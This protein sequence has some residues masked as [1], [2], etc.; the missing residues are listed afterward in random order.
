VYRKLG[1]LE[2]AR[3]HLR[4]GLEAARVLQ[5]SAEPPDGY[6]AMIIDALARLGERLDDAVDTGT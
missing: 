2:E 1:R 5:W 4:H 6:Q 3:D